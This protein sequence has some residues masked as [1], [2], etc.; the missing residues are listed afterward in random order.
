MTPCCIWKAPTF[1]KSES[2]PA[3]EK[4]QHIPHYTADK[5]IAA[6]KQF[7]SLTPVRDL[8]SLR[9]QIGSGKK[10]IIFEI[11]HQEEAG[12]MLAE[13]RRN[14]PADQDYV[15]MLTSSPLSDGVRASA[16]E[17]WRRR[18]QEDGNSCG[19]EDN[20]YCVYYANGTTVTA[21]VLAFVMF[22]FLYIGICCMMEIE[23]PM[24]YPNKLIKI[25]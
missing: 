24:R 9:E 14:L 23:T 10:S 4:G 20:D 6:L 3:G 11:R 19:D 8:E 7:A 1:P 22:I 5:G 18:L 25:R 12:E 2:L 15:V 13:V 21:I 16:R 17:R